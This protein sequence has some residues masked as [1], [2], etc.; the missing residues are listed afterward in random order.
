MKK[1]FALLMAVTLTFQLVTPVF[2]EDTEQANIDTLPQETEVLVDETKG[3]DETEEPAETEEPGETEKPTEADAP[4]AATE[5]DKTGAAET[6][7]TEAEPSEESSALIRVTF[8]RTPADLTLTVYAADTN[9]E[10]DPQEDDTYLLAPGEYTYFA[11]LDGYISE[12]NTF[13]VSE[14]D[15]VNREISVELQSA[16]MEDDASFDSGDY[17]LQL[18]RIDELYERIKKNGGFFTVNREPCVTGSGHRGCDNCKLKNVINSDWFTT[19][20]GSNVTCSKFAMNTTGSAYTCTAFASFAGWFVNRRDDNDSVSTAS[21][22]SGDFSFEFFSSCA[23]PG[24]SILMIVGKQTHNAIFI[25]CNKQGVYVLD[26]N[27][28]GRACEVTKQ[29]IPYSSKWSTVTI[30]HLKSEQGGHTQ[31]TAPAAPTNF[32]AVYVD[33]ARAKLSW[34]AS[35]GATSYEVQ[36][37]SVGSNAWKTDT[38]YSSGTS[39]TSTGL[40]NY[41]SWTFRVRAVNSAGKSDWVSCNYEKTHTHSYKQEFEAAHPH[42]VYMKCSSCG[43]WYYTGAT[44]TVDSCTQCHPPVQQ[45]YLDLKGY[46]DGRDSDSL[47]NFGTCDVYINDVKV[48]DDCTDFYRAYPVGTKYSIKDI[49]ATD[50]H[51]YIGE[52][53]FVDEDGNTSIRFE[54]DD[55]TISGTLKKNTEV[56]LE[57]ETT[58]HG[59]KCGDNLTWTLDGNGTLTISGSGAMSNF[60]IYQNVAPWLKNWD[61]IARVV[62]EP[63]VT[64]IGDYTFLGCAGLTN[65]TIPD[66]VTYIGYQAFGDCKSLASVTIPGSV[67]NI[68]GFAFQ[69]C[70]GLT[71]MTILEGATSIGERAFTG[72]SSLTSV[73]IPG[74]VVSIGDSAFCSCSGLTSVTIRK[75]VTSI[76]WGA[77]SGCSGL[78]SITIPES[79]TSIK[80]YAF[81]ENALK[82]IEV[83]TGN[84][85]YC[86]VDGV[87]YD[88]NMKN[89]LVY[90]AGSTEN[91][92]NIPESV[93]HIDDAAF[94]DCTSLNRITIPESV[95]SIGSYAFSGCSGLS[96]VHLSNS[97]SSIGE[98]AFDGCNNLADVFYSGTEQQWNS[99]QIS[100][101]NTCLTNARLHFNSAEVISGSCGKNLTWAITENGVLKISGTGEMQDY[102][103]CEDGETVYSSAPWGRMGITG[104]KLGEG[105]TRIGAC[106]FLDCSDI[107][108]ALILPRT[109]KEIG[110]CA[111]SGCYGISGTLNFP[112]NLEKIEDC[113]FQ[114]CDGLYGTLQ[115]PE[116]LSYIGLATFNGCSGFT[117]QL[118]IPKN[119]Q[120]IGD[121][122][123]RNCSG[124]TNV[125]IPG[126]VATIGSASF[127]G[128]SS[129]T[130]ITI[131]KGVTS[132]E[133]E[134]FSGCSS[135]TSVTI[136][137]SV[138]S[139]GDSAFSSCS[140]LTSVTIPESVTSIGDW[141]FSGCS[142]LTSVRIPE[143][144]TSIGER[145][146][147]GCSSLTSVRIPESVT[148]IG[149]YAFY[150]CSSLTKL[151]IPN[152]VTSIGNSAFEGCSSLTSVRIPEGVTSIGWDAFYGCSGLTSI[153]IPKSVTSIEG[154]AF[155]GCSSLT[156]IA[157]PDGVTRIGYSAFS[158]C[159]SLTSITIPES[160]TSIEGATF[161]GCS[162]LTSVRIP[163]GVTS[164]EHETFSCCTS[165]I[166][167][168]IPEGVTSI[169]N[170]TFSRC[171]SLTSVRIP[172]SVTSIGEWA[173]F[174]CVELKDIYYGGAKTDW[175][176]IQIAKCNDSLLDA[177]IH[178]QIRS[179]SEIRPVDASTLDGGATLKLTLWS[180]DQ[181]K[182]IGAAWS[183]AEGSEAYAS[184]TASGTLT[185]KAVTEP[186]EITVI[187]QPTNGEPT[188]TKT[189]RITPKATALLL[190][191]DGEVLGETLN[192]DM[193]DLQAL[194]L[195]AIKNTMEEA[196]GIHW[197]TS[198][199]T[200]AQV[201]AKGL[202]T[203]LKPGRAVI[204]A[205]DSGKLTG[206]VTLNVTYTDK[207]PRLEATT[208][209][210]NTALSGGVTVD[211]VEAYGN[212]V[213]ALQW[214]DARFLFEYQEN[215]L[216]VSAKDALKNGTYPVSLTAACADGRTYE[217]PLTLK[218]TNT[219]PKVTVMQTAKLNLFYRDSE[220]TLTI[221][222]GEVE[223]AAFI[224]N[225]DF[226]LENEDDQWFIR[227]ADPENIPAKPSTKATLSVLFAGYNTPVT[228]SVTIATV[229]TSP[230]LKLSP[231]SSVLNTVLTEALEVR[232]Q[233]AGTD[234]D[235]LSVWTDTPGAEVYLDDGTLTI[236]LSAAKAVT[237]NV[238][239]QSDS[240]A[241]PVKLTHKVSVT[242]KKP[243]L[244]AVNSTLKLNSYFPS[245]T[246]STGL[247]LSQGN[248]SLSTVELTPTAKAG[249]AATESEKL[250]VSYDLDSEEIVAEI[251]DSSIKNGTYSF[252]CVGTL[253]D[254][255]TISGGTVKVSVT[256]T[257]PKAKLSASTV[258]LNKR[259]T[260]EEATVKVTLTG[261]NGYTVTGFENLPDF[262]WYEDGILTVTLPEQSGTY[263]LYATVSRG[264]EEAVLPT[265]VKLTVQVYDKVP[266]FRLSAKGKLDVLNPDSEIIY[267]PKLTNALG[268]ASD[269]E[270][271]GANAGL[272]DAEVV[273]GTIHLTLAK[274]GDNYS[275]KATYKIVPLLTIC[276]QQVKG[277]ALSIKVTQSALKLASLPNRTVY[278]SQATPLLQ[279]LHVT[280]P[281]AAEVGDVTLNAKTSAALRS[282][283]DTAGG[284]QSRGATIAFPAKAFTGLKP[285][286]YTVILDITPVNAASDSKPTQ[287]KFT[288]TVKK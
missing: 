23:R 264:G 137:G 118:D 230:K 259:L 106:A 54:D 108:G 194:T 114:G 255:T 24:D 274:S 7:P 151:T 145:A 51:K 249:A 129:L 185:A 187:A 37:W 38:S 5:T 165:L 69:N 143:G 200:V 41:S 39:Y 193:Y 234:D 144:V 29:T 105:I 257:L 177:T 223:S 78:T 209:N 217:Y 173:F 180:I 88:K 40:K 92:F 138:V 102:E 201:D 268:T 152:S 220:S 36:Y 263:P 253:E 25:S 107:S 30:S 11:E 282:A 71:S 43:D 244:K 181:D 281:A 130:S 153:T 97:V 246:A 171:S 13:T 248:L 123:F 119:V 16:D 48:A 195:T 176:Q 70:T 168:T 183:L 146:F 272:F 278:T 59:G 156:S 184:I 210:L 179:I 271:T 79:V 163:E 125:S 219:L 273:N 127:G 32:K 162:S 285:G 68:G 128:C 203:L 10:I 52:K 33:N 117:G 226:A 67:R 18:S 63:G 8:I 287:A 141:A 275:T 2:A 245:E 120:E 166:S 250:S 208:L 115:L 240:W 164:I 75:G 251:L 95:T 19:E 20:F 135:L 50:G 191:R 17:S 101:D 131:P 31:Q 26:G 9:T 252:A 14:V 148:S 154:G 91:S 167:I 182:Q 76:G 139:I 3:P 174:N 61:K 90:P 27:N 228:K 266:S 229:N 232:A 288:L 172:E 213:E 196:Q 73:T 62:V 280:A 258:K 188:A 56:V 65:V 279:T 214:N 111:F 89:L 55:G 261:G 4:S 45:V 72:C 190:M 256:N 134:A 74:S 150:G 192:A 247:I 236:E 147:T 6:V 160:V 276:D 221:T 83:A 215:R 86:A 53:P 198:A 84:A 109:L 122:A 96:E 237:V 243:T 212:G 124:L 211:F 12:E 189:I 265:A 44:T 85:N 254:G 66:G 158:G 98:K 35:S 216:T 222:G 149:E 227:Y 224:G 238:Y 199:K 140:G 178:Y 87:L 159:S 15:E 202:V 103:W 64:S 206:K 157:I 204:Q 233:L 42:K 80:A 242:T 93:S 284:L 110:E 262:M 47:E 1:L 175:K 277:P 136:P 82:R 270:L 126:R 60:F 225:S 133:S 22:E 77:F 231:S 112:E 186:V 34:S 94:F 49:R 57:F 121:W 170:A 267:T 116:K 99:I 58:S 283:L 241:K 207:S 28:T 132:I 113:A 205:T 81:M 260:G 142:S 21:R 155:S 197:S 46:L 100:E 239:V 286:N 169:E 104:L 218:V 269:V 235:N 161:S